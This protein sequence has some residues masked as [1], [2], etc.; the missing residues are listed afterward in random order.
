MVVTR[1]WDLNFDSTV[2]VGAFLTFLT[3]VT[4]IVA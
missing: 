4:G 3:L 1:L 2:D